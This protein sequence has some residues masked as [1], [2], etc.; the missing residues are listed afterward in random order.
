MAAKKLSPEDLKKFDALLR[1]LLGVLTGDI[2]N[3][4]SEA[5][6]GNGGQVSAEDAGCE[7]NAAELSLEL[8]S[9]DENTVREIMEALDRIQNKT[10]GICTGCK[11]PIKKT[12]LRYM[13]HARNCIECQRM[14]EGT[15][16]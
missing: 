4:E 2:Q 10:F 5:F 8:L 12:R 6:G 9:R 16:G 15:A 1:Q 13:P 14:A 11:K 7:I 3:L